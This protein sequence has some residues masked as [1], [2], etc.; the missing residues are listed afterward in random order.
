MSEPSN[1]RRRP[2]RLAVVLAV[3]AVVAVGVA[4]GVMNPGTAPGS[5]PTAPAEP[6]DSKLAPLAYKRRVKVDNS[7]SLEVLR[8]IPAWRPDAPPKRLNKH[9]DIRR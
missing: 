9:S 8:D 7:G 5:R 3:A 1:P 2:R 4:A 6:D